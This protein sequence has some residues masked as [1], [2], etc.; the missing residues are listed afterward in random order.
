[1]VRAT[2]T[3]AE[4]GQTSSHGPPTSF[5]MDGAES[6]LEAVCRPPLL[7][8]K[9][10]PVLSCDSICGLNPASS[11]ASVETRRAIAMTGSTPSLIVV[12]GIADGAPA[13]GGDPDH[14]GTVNHRDAERPA[15][16][17]CHVDSRSEPKGVHRPIPVITTRG[18]LTAATWKRGGIVTTY[19]LRPSAGAADSEDCPGEKKDNH[20]P[21]HNIQASRHGHIRRRWS[22]CRSCLGQWNGKRTGVRLRNNSCGSSC[23]KQCEADATNS[24]SQ[25]C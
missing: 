18:A 13:T 25:S 9:T 21:F 17:D 16:S 4:F 6:N 23:A 5:R 3:A 14:C 19:S 22:R 11:I 15:S 20:D 7:V 24:T 8:P 2:A 1:M 10:T 12:G